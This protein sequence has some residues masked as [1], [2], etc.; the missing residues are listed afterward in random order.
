MF[1][2]FMIV[3]VS[4]TF[5]FLMVLLDNAHKERM[6]RIKHGLP[7]EERSDPFPSQQQDQR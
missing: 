7:P 3:L 1:W 5:A 6:E 2:V 4:L